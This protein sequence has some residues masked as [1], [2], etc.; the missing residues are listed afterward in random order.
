MCAT[1]GRTVRGARLARTIAPKSVIPE[2]F[3]ELTHAEDSDAVAR[4]IGRG[5]HRDVRAVDHAARGRHL[6]AACERPAARH[7]VAHHTIPRTREVLTG[8]G[9]VRG[10]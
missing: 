9:P 6:E 8:R 5:A 1:A 3:P 4:P 10:M 2:T 7:G